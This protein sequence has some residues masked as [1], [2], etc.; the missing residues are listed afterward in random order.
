MKHPIA[1]FFSTRP[2]IVLRSNCARMGPIPIDL[3]ILPPLFDL[4]SVSGSCIAALSLCTMSLPQSS[5][6]VI[7]TTDLSI[8]PPA[9][10]HGN[11]WY[12]GYT[13]IKHF[14]FRESDVDSSL[15][16]EE[17]TNI[18]AW[19]SLIQDVGETLAVPFTLPSSVGG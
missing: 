7:E 14:V 6:K 15:T 5:L 8:A 16:N 11:H 3:F 2:S 19:E 1:N 9:L 4:P 18:V 13:A 10:K 12:R 17:K